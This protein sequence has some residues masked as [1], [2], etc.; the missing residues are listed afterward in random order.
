MHCFL[1][2]IFRVLRHYMLCCLQMLLLLLLLLLLAPGAVA[3]S[4][5]APDVVQ[6]AGASFQH[7]EVKAAWH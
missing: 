4:A 3:E 6:V 7:Y 5:V 1:V 2:I